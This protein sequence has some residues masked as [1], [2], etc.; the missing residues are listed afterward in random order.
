MK[1][2]TPKHGKAFG[3]LGPYIRGLVTYRLSPFEQR[4][5]AGFTASI[6]KTIR[7][8][9]SNIP[10]IAPPAILA[11]LIY[12]ATEQKAL[13]MQRKNPADYENDK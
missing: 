11:Y 13:Q 9:A 1:L 8:I 2:T 3:N 10:Y 12:S 7:R 5:F 4:A 6:P